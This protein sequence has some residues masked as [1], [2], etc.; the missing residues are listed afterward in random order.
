M[1]RLG[2][3]A[4]LLAW[5]AAL[6]C[7]DS[8]G[9]YLLQHQHQLAR[10]NKSLVMSYV[11]FNF[12]HTVAE[13]VAAYG[14]KWG[15]CG[16][17]D[18]IEDCVGWEKSE[19]TGCD[20][21]YTPGKLWPKDLAESYFG[22]RTIFGILR[23]P[24]ERLVAQFRG[25][26]RLEHPELLCDVDAGV[27]MML[28][29]YL[30]EVQ[31]G[32]PWAENCNYLPQAEFFDQPFGGTIFV[33]NRHFPDS[34]NE[35]FKDFGYGIHIATAEVSHVSGC[36]EKWAADLSQET[37]DLVYQVYHRDFELLC[38]HFGYCDRNESICLKRVPEMCPPQ[39]FDWNSEKEMYEV[40]QSHLQSTH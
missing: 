9:V 12:G 37:R 23:D 17:R 25:T 20:M 13:K 21:M 33:D 30:A 29:N 18:P 6:E 3:G 14:I 19:V 39:L 24:Y 27:K 10:R 15:D 28:Q 1:L 38:K 36:D 32:N 26:Y 16:S 8:Q 7:E 11:P 34:M 4:L 40:R 22:N 35:V 5:A 2:H 31:A